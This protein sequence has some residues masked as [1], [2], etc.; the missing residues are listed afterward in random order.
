MLLNT[1]HQWD[2]RNQEDL[3]IF[4]EEIEIHQLVKQANRRSDNITPRRSWRNFQAGR[5]NRPMQGEDHPLPKRRHW[6][7]FMNREEFLKQISTDL[8]EGYLFEEGHV[9]PGVRRVQRTPRTRQEHS[10]R[11]SRCVPSSST[12]MENRSEQNS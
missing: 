6:G 8:S 2:I 12:G 1:V 3:D 4:R 10:T 9:L 7:P 11:E 5:K